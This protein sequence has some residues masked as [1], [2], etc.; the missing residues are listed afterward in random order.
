MSRCYDELI[1]I[2]SFK[3]RYEYLK[4]N[5]RPFE[6]TFGSHRYLNQTLYQSPEWRS[7][8]RKVII[9]DNACDMAHEDFPITGSVYIHHLNPITIEDIVERNACVFDMNNLVCV[10][11]KT[12][13][14]IHFGDETQIPEI[15]VPRSF[16]DTK[17]W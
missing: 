6:S 2:F 4:V 12:H 16:G 14:A 3:E 5:G 13:T 15:F 9:R 11:F 17:L 10:S 1:K 7:V 8:R